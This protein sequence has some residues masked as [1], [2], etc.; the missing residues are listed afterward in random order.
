M[1]FATGEANRTRAA[2]YG[3][4]RARGVDCADGPRAAFVCAKAARASAKC[5]ASKSHFTLRVSKGR[6][7][8]R[9]VSRPTAALQPLTTALLM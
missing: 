6:L 1:A 5:P 2:A 7:A 8:F 3:A 9:E 4:K